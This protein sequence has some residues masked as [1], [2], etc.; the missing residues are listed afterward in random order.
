MTIYH[1]L[2][3]S[4]HIRYFNQHQ[5]MRQ[6]TGLW[7][8]TM[9]LKSSHSASVHTFPALDPCVLHHGLPHFTPYSCTSDV[10]WNLLSH[11]HPDHALMS[12][13]C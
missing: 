13:K 5:L 9:C 12:Q 4:I 2:I 11:T 1:D 3:V 6:F 8:N 7:K 10:M